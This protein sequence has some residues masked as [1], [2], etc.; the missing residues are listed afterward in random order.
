MEKNKTS[1]LENGLIWFGASVSIAELLTGTLIAPLGFAKGLAAILLGHVI[2]CVLLYFAGLIGAYKGISAMETVKLSFGGRGALF[3][4]VMNVLQL[5]GWTAVMIGQ[6]ADS[7]AA[8]GFSGILASSAFW[9]VIIGALIIV[10][11]VIG[12]TN[13]GRLNVCVMAALFVMTVVLSVIVFKIGGGIFAGASG[14]GAEA[15]SFGAAAE[16]S[17][18]MPISWLPLISD[19]TRSAGKPRL[20]TGTS[21]IVYFAGSC[22]MFVIGMAAA[23]FTGNDSIADIMLGAGTG[24]VGLL[25]VTLSTV[26]TTFLDAYS[27]GVSSVSIYGKIKE[28]P[29]AVAVAVSG[30]LLAVFAPVNRLEGFLYLIGSVFAPMIAILISDAFILKRDRSDRSVDIKNI[31]IWIIGFVIYRAFLYIDTPAGNTL[32]VI[33][34]VILICV[35]AEFTGGLLRKKD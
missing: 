10:W 22:W 7:A 29:A 9:A 18:A 16:L 33:I 27:A 2:G 11:I 26:T 5:V 4:A 20:A 15:L 13:I 3:F 31:A 35:A 34:I 6:G 12:V 23:L 1:V 30:I 8:M 19:Y 17:A 24:I 28:K 14:G 25:I 21:V 32:P